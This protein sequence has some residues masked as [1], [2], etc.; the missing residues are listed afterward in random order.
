MMGIRA[1][2]IYG[3]LQDWDIYDNRYDIER[4]KID[5]PLEELDA[6]DDEQIADMVE[7]GCLYSDSPLDNSF[8]TLLENGADGGWFKWCSRW[9]LGDP[10]DLELVLFEEEE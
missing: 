9:E 5:V 3:V 1:A 8:G 6:F 4:V 7:N 2:V 10:C